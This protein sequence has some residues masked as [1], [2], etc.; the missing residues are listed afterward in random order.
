MLALHYARCTQWNGFHQINIVLS[1]SNFLCDKDLHF[2]RHF[3]LFSH[4][5]YMKLLFRLSYILYNV[6]FK[7]TSW[8]CYHKHALISIKIDVFTR[9]INENNRSLKIS[10]F[11]EFREDNFKHGVKRLYNKPF[12]CSPLLCWSLLTSDFLKRSAHKISPLPISIAETFGY[13]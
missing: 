7:H 5:S 2:K 3:P 11:W 13:N 10:N 12:P 4:A 9:R 6:H 8:K 1:F